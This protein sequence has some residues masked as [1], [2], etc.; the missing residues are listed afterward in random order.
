MSSTP[1][2]REYRAYRVYGRVQGV[3]FRWWTRGV[4]EELGV[5]GAVRNLADGSVEVRASGDSETLDRLAD[6]LREGPRFAR[7]E[8]VEEIDTEPLE[9]PSAF[10]IEL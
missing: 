8:R 2:N 9:E 1:A 5:G 4:A 7:V 10:R 6:K 3:G